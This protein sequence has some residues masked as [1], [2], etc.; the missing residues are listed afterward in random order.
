[1]YYIP[2]LFYSSGRNG[3][4]GLSRARIRPVAI[5][6]V[7]RDNLYGDSGA[8]SEDL[9]ER[10]SGEYSPGSSATRR[11]RLWCINSAHYLGIF[12]E[13]GT[14]K[15]RQIH[16]F[17]SLLKILLSDICNDEETFLIFFGKL[18]SIKNK[19]SSKFK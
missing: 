12:L 8:S 2:Q 15:N 17:S 7:S 10:D 16:I 6:A 18:I 19:N 11:A 1:M 3:D 5:Y 4:G 14:V 9:S 13:D